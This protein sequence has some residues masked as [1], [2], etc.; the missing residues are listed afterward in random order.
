MQVDYQ[1]FWITLRN[2]QLCRILDFGYAGAI[3]KSQNFSGWQKKYT[4]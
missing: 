1:G 2:L 3:S 4:K